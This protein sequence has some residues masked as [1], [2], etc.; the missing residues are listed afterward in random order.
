MNAHPGYG[1]FN[2][3]LQN[4]IAG[5]GGTSDKSIHSRF[6]APLVTGADVLNAYRSSW[7]ARKIV[8]IVPEDMTREWRAWQ[9][10]DDQITA[11]EVEEK[12]LKIRAKITDAY[13]WAR[14]FGGAAVILGADTGKP[15]EPLVADGVKKGGLRYIHVVPRSR[16]SVGLMDEDIES[17][18]FD[19]P[20]SYRLSSAA[21]QVELH[22]SR[23]IVF[24]GNEPPPETG[25]D[26]WGESVLV[27]IHQALVNAETVSSVIAALLLEAKI[28]IVQV[29]DL[30][31]H[32]STQEGTDR[33]VRRF[34][35]AQ[36][37]KSLNHT[38]L[39]GTGEVHTTKQIRFAGL[40]EIH[41]RFMQEISG[42]ADIPITRLLG[43]SPAGLNSTGESDM[44]MYYDMIRSKQNDDLAAALDRIDNLLIRSALGDRPEEIYYEFGALW[45]ASAAE[46]A[47]TNLK[48]AQAFQIDVNANVFGDEVLLEA[49]KN[50]I[51]ETQAYPGFEQIVEEAAQVATE[52]EEPIVIEP[53]VLGAPANQNEPAPR[54]APRAVGDRRIRLRDG[55]TIRMRPFRRNV[56]TNKSAN[57]DAAPRTLYVSRSVLNAREIIAWA[58][59]QGF[60]ST[61]PAEDMHVTVAFSRAPVDWMRVG[62]EWPGPDGK[63]EVRIPPGGARLVEPLGDK[64]AIVLLF[65]SSELS[66]RHEDIKRAGASWDFPEYQ[67]HV[68]ITYD[69]TGV[70]LDE[71]EPYR[72][73][74]LLGPEIFAEVDDDW[75]TKV[76]EE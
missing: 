35:A 13:R 49:R 46:K 58:K 2:D 29:P 42:A 51:I 33:L 8:D 12:R 5:L 74:I 55:R 17:E 16:L 43:Q 22:H 15:T 50:Q 21:N 6:V 70:D 10:E 67:P 28:D 59:G 3:S 69:G 36:L 66:W 54:V 56:P 1:P 47:D 20:G 4:L 19:H 34:Q 24:K 48:N 76:R 62:T 25:A 32:L 18:N 73:P 38:L 41:M 23:V 64:G 7:I 11:I 39:L 60:S 57:S 71:V 63:G 31:A 14:L 72:G 65:N 40:P 37:L 26:F 30:V 75:E 68:T 52:E 61:V 53:S 9:A 27:A 44:R 45:Q